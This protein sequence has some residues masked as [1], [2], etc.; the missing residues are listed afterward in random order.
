MDGGLV[1]ITRFDVAY[2]KDNMTVSF[3]LAGHTALMNERV[4]SKY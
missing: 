4:T 2:Y 3:H 1:D